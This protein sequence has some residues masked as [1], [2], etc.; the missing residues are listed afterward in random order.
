MRLNRL[1]EDLY[2][3]ALSDQ[4]ALSY[5]KVLLNPAP[6]LREDIAAFIPD[7]NQKQIHVQWLDRLS[8]PVLVNADPDRLSQLFR[9]LL[10]NSLNHTDPD[11]QMKI[12]IQRIKDELLIEFTDSS[13]GVSAQDIA[14][15]FDRFY[16]VD[17]SRNRHLGGAGLGLAICNNIVKAH[18]GTLS[19]SHSDLGGITM[20]IAL[21]VAS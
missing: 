2:Q 15:L 18:E 5:R 7:F 4:G 3:L 9:N 8:K 17:S 16:R 14:H 21:P 11:G 13:P 1:T 12:I 10:T 6:I 20:R 19:A